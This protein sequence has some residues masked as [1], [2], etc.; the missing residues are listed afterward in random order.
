[1]EPPCIM[2]LT[3]ARIV[4]ALPGAFYISCL[5]MRTFIVFVVDGEKDIHRDG[6]GRTGGRRD[7]RTEGGT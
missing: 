7:R 1:M 4:I 2:V 6:E 5:L 3:R